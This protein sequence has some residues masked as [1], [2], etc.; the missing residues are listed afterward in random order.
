L[1]E[2]IKARILIVSLSAEEV[3]ETLPLPMEDVFLWA[4]LGQGHL[5]M[6]PIPQREVGKIL[7]Y[8]AIRTWAGVREHN[9]VRR[10]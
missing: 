3:V 10:H 8:P 2:V 9:M 1:S 4:H 5:E 6:E 7:G